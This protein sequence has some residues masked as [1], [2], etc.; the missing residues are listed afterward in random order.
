MQ[1]S[2][3]VKKISGHHDA[4]SEQKY[5]NLPK[6]LDIAIDTR[7][8]VAIV[9][10]DELSEENYILLR[11]CKPFREFPGVEN[12]QPIKVR[13]SDGCELG[14]ITY[15]IAIYSYNHITVDAV[16]EEPDS[17]VEAKYSSHWDWEK[18]EA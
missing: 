7:G 16:V 12:T 2:F 11:M 18:E 10:R 14:G 8:I 13:V 5:E 4:W 6:Y 1:H 9:T 3:H 15:D 17:Y